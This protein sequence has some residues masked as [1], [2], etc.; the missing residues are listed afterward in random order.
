[1]L[2]RLLP[3][4][5]LL[6]LVLAAS[7]GAAGPPSA[8]PSVVG[9]Q[10][11]L[12]EDWP[13]IAFVLSGWDT[14]GDGTIDSA[15]NCTGTVVA[16]AW[17]LTAAHCAFD[18]DDVLADAMLAVLGSA[19]VTV[20]EAETLAADSV[21]V[22]PDWDPMTLKGD[23]LLV[24]LEEESAQPPMPLA[25]PQ[26]EYFLD[27]TLP[28]LAGWGTTD[29]DNTLD[30]DILQEA[31][32]TV[33]DLTTEGIETCAAYDPGGYD[34]A[35]QTCAGEFEVA[36]ACHGDSGGPLTVLD[37]GGVPQ[38]WGLTSYGPAP[39][40]GTYKQCDLRLPVIF[41]WVPAF[42]AWVEETVAGD[43]PVPPPP[44]Q[45]LVTQPPPT[46]P[47]PT[48]PAD[49]RAPELSDVKLS[50]KR[51]K[52]ARRG[53]TLARKAGAKLSFTLDEAAVVSVTVRTRGKAR[54]APATLAADAGKTTRRFTARAAG[55]KLKRG[56][57]RLR[58]G[59]VDAAGNAATPVTL[60]FRVV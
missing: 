22:H 36:G 12:I 3:V 28:N 34:P 24:H 25:R 21:V 43:A 55:K 29:E 31:F 18:P 46:A 10:E 33:I 23:V 57:Y 53:A 1:V 38:L 13:S 44:P 59:A 14:D 19:D 52:P 37:A 47:L 42:G 20:E 30:T 9:G 56:R 15:A 48:L 2:R 41:S 60:R 17:I 27:D 51:I 4:F 45:P 32:V 6:T 35:T 16:P 11:A 50:T 40:D 49:A 7:A 58:V 5:L 26:V 8:S 39:P 54:G